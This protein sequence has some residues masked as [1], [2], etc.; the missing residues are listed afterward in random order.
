[1]VGGGKQKPTK[2]QKIEEKKKKLHS[3]GLQPAVHRRLL[4]AAEK[5]QPVVSSL[6]SLP[7]HLLPRWKTS[8]KSNEVE[9]KSPRVSPRNPAC[10]GVKE[11]V[12]RPCTG[13]FRRWRMSEIKRK[14]NRCEEGLPQGKPALLL[15]AD[16]Q[17]GLFSLARPRGNPTLSQRGAS[18]LFPASPRS[19]AR[20]RELYLGFSQLLGY[21]QSPGGMHRSCAQLPAP[22]PRPGGEGCRV[23]TRLKR[24]KCC[25]AKLWAVFPSRKRQKLVVRARQTGLRASSLP[26]ERCRLPAILQTVEVCMISGSGGNSKAPAEAG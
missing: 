26:P 4:K 18:L 10:D 5:S 16:E 14:R 8:G 20:G 6:N 1:M 19:S 24:S 11:S 12:P 22:A 3:C 7:R 17:R 15:R 13:G 9:K 23:Q 21:S 25:K 2:H